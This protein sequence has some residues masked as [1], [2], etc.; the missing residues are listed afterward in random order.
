VSVSG[1]LFDL[2][3]VL[4]RSEELAL[5]AWNE[6][7]AE[8]GNALSEEQ[9]TRMIGEAD[10]S[11]F[12][13]T[14]FNL[15]MTS[16]DIKQDHRKRVMRLLETDLEPMP[17]AF[18]IVEELKARGFP[19]AI[20]SNSLQ[21]YVEKALEVSGL[22]PYFQAV[23]ARD[24]VDHPKPAPDVYQHAA[25]LIGL[26]SADCLSIEDSPIGMQAALAAKTRCVVVPHESLRERDFTGAYA[27]Y[28]TLPDLQADLGSLL[29]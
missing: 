12:I 4:I 9:Y 24:L 27:R 15:D 11:S 14:F 10:T 17:G 1:V 19:L 29:S 28:E 25:R 7:L 5:Q 2:D 22:R 23:V 3:G 8:S 21:K 18:E 13:L 26:D 20:A 16:A 6:F